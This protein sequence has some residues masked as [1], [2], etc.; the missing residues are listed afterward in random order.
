[1]SDI[2]TPLQAGPKIMGEEGYSMDHPRFQT[3]AKHSPGED[4]DTYHDEFLTLVEIT[5]RL[6]GSR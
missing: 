4:P 5:K 3:A 1:M 6:A 2:G